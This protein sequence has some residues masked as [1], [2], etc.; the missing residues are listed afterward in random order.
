MLVHATMYNIII[1]IFTILRLEVSVYDW[2]W[3]LVV[4]VVHAHGY[5]LGPEQ[6]LMKVNSV[7]S[8]VV[9]QSTGFS[10]FC[11]WSKVGWGEYC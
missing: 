1:E 10:I 9:V 11:M 4:K 8:Q 6:D 5:L 2:Y 7:Q 3:S